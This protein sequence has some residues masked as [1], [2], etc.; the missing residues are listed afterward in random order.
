MK[1]FFKYSFSILIMI[2][3]L[4]LFGIMAFKVL[5]LEDSPVGKGDDGE[6]AVEQQP[7]GQDSDADKQA[8]AEPPKPTVADPKAAPFAT[9]DPTYLSLSLIHI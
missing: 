5:I 6:V 2:S 1:N 7:E 9:A 8:E 4:I 3:C